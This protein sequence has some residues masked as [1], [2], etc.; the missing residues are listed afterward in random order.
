[1][2]L[3][4]WSFKRGD[5]FKAPA[6]I[7]VRVNGVA[8]D[9][10]DSD[11]TVLIQARSTENDAEPAATFTPDPDLLAAGKVRPTLARAIS[12][13]MSGPYVLDVAVTNDNTGLG[14]KSSA[15]WTLQVVPDVSREEVGS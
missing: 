14:R 6:S 3:P 11:W 12:K 1:M 15:V 7:Q 13:D 2:T 10:S 9:L 8:P 4:D 5:D